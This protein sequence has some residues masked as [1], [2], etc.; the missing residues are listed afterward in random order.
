MKAEYRGKIGQTLM[1]R[2][3][4]IAEETGWGRIDWTVNINNSNGIQFDEKIGAN[5]IEKV[6]LCRL[7][8]KAIRDF[9]IKK[10]PKFS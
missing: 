6:R 8:N 4:Q 1:P 9:Q 10:N 5:I 2:L 3:C 7:D